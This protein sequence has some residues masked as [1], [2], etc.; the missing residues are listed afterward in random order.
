MHNRTIDLARFGAAAH[1]EDDVRDA[2]RSRMW[3]IG[4]GLLCLIAWGV[5]L[6]SWFRA[7]S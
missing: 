6:W 5:A 4:W 7:A 3:A 2:D 1:A